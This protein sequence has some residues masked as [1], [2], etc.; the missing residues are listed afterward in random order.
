MVLTNMKKPKLIQAAL[1]TIS[2]AILLGLFA[3][4][5]TIQPQEVAY[6]PYSKTQYIDVHQASHKYIQRWLR[7]KDSFFSKI[8]FI[9]VVSSPK[10]K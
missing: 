4:M 9:Y 8:S 3:K 2:I 10:Y 6:D 1:I 5:Q 7:K